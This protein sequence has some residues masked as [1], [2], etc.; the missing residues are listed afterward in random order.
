MVYAKLIQAMY[1]E[2]KMNE[3]RIGRETQEFSVEISVHQGLAFSPFVFLFLL[4]IYYETYERS[5]G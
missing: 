1:F 4:V 5:T 2:A 3:K